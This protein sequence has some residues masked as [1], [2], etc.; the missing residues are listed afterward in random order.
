MKASG[1][2]FFGFG[3]LIFNGGVSITISILLAYFS[4]NMITVFVFSA[5]HWQYFALTFVCSN[6]QHL[7]IAAEYLAL[8]TLDAWQLFPLT[9]PSSVGPL[10]STPLVMRHAMVCNN[11][12][13][14]WHPS[15]HWDYWDGGSCDFFEAV[16][17]WGGISWSA[18]EAAKSPTRFWGVRLFQ[19][20]C[21]DTSKKLTKPLILSYLIFR[22]RFWST[23]FCVS[24]HSSPELVVCCCYETMIEVEVAI[25]ALCVAF[26]QFWPLSQLCTGN[27]RACVVINP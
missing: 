25:P 17:C 5:K 4:S 16:R 14:H 20:N 6:P 13:W 3:F 9:V 21:Q 10:P 1:A 8:S 23:S 26:D 15:N 22:H 19:S 2:W 7:L 24:I 18:T 11:L 12:R 27:Q